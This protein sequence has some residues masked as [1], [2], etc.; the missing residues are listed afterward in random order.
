M[1]WSRLKIKVYLLLILI[2]LTCRVDAQTLPQTLQL[3]SPA[4]GSTLNCAGNFIANATFE[5]TTTN[6][7]I[8]VY[9][10]DCSSYPA[11]I[12][13][14]YVFCYGTTCSLNAPNTFDHGGPYTVTVEAYTRYS[15]TPVN[16]T[17]SVDCTPLLVSIAAPDESVSGDFDIVGNVNFQPRPGIASVSGAISIY[18]NDKLIDSMV[19]PTESC[20]YSYKRQ[21]G[22]LYTLPPGGPYT[23]VLKADAYSGGTA[24]DKKILYV[25]SAIPEKNQGPPDCS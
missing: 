22:K 13:F 10:G 6:R 5:P 18:L 19:C 24:S 17:F 8:W 11:C 2:S 16:T 9:N 23:L 4:T 14:A 3:I 7:G 12:V 1:F 25:N 20:S 15:K 21:H